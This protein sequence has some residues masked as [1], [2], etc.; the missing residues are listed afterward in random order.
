MHRD[1][2]AVFAVGREGWEEQV[3]EGSVPFSILDRF[4]SPRWMPDHQNQDY[5]EHA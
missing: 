4:R 1:Q 3:H 2:A 5:H